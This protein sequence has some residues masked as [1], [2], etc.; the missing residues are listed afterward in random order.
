M[1]DK[2][3]EAF[4]KWKATPMGIAG[5]EKMLATDMHASPGKYVTAAIEDAFKAG[6]ERGP[7]SE[8]LDYLQGLLYADP[9][10]FRLWL[11]LPASEPFSTDIRII[12]RIHKEKSK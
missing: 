9:D 4:E 12:T 1:S 6:C 11:D 3:R 2:I 10:R 8:L 5:C 7:D